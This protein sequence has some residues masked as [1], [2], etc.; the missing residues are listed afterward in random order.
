MVN[1]VSYT[2]FIFFAVER[3]AK[4]VIKVILKITGVGFTI[5]SLFFLIL[6]IFLLCRLKRY[7]KEFY[8]EH[9]CLLVLAT[10]G[11]SFP[12]MCRGIFDTIRGFD[13]KVE[14]VLTLHENLFNSL[15]MIL[16]NLVPIVFQLSSLVFGYIRNKK[17]KR[18]KLVVKHC[19]SER[20][21]NHNSVLS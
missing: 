20:K 5:L 6:S 14:K 2:L 17:N 18:H 8:N 16:W 15:N 19:K 21:N 13:K 12:I 4:I 7:F 11:L 9:W 10:I 1:I 3:T